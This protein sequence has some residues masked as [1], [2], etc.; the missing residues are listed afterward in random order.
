MKKE[1]ELPDYAKAFVARDKMGQLF[2][3]K[4]LAL[5]HSECIYEYEVN[6]DHYNPNGILHGGALYAVMDSSQGMFVHAILDDQF[7]AAATGTATIKYLAPVRHGKIKI[8]TTL[9]GQENRKIF[10]SSIAFDETGIKVADLDE[11]WIAMLK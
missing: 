9:K 2:G 1:S 3:A 8:V 11:V 6:E 7:K 4:F 5:S 10:V